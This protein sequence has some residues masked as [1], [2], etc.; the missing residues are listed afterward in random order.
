V[1]KASL[2]KSARIKDEP[3]EDLRKKP[4][5]KAADKAAPK[6]AGKTSSKKGATTD[7]KAKPDTKSPAKKIL[8]SKEILDISVLEKVVSEEHQYA[9]ERDIF[10]PI[11]RNYNSKRNAP[12]PPRVIKK[13]KK[14]ETKK[15]ELSAE[16]M[17][18]RMAD[19]VRSS[20]AFEGYVMRNARNLAL[21]TLNGEFFVVG[22]E[23]VVMNKVKIVKVEKKKL[24]VEVESN[25]F[26]IKLKGDDE[27]ENE[28]TE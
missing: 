1:T 7:P 13:T 27:D 20:L 26:E 4:V 3:S 21:V 24:T 25:E 11:K 18:Q 17:R 15:R 5:K 8:P 2:K 22:K 6:K 28:S 9:L 10:S 19:E 12:P 23:D 14:A 16:E